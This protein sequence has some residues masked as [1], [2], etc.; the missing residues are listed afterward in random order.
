[1]NSFA[2]A[3]LQIG[4]GRTWVGRVVRRQARY[5]NCVL[6]IHKTITRIVDRRSQNLFRDLADNKGLQGRQSADD[7]KRKYSDSTDSDR[8]S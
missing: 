3:I 1:M 2:T 8:A 7:W 4:S 5:I 6:E